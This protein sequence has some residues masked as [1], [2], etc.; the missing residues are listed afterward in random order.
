MQ[1]KLL[2]AAAA[3]AALAA[4]ASAHATTYDLGNLGG[5]GVITHTSPTV[6]HTAGT[7]TDEFDFTASTGLMEFTTGAY[8]EASPFA[9]TSA[10]FTLYSDATGKAITSSGAFDPQTSVTPTISADLDAGKY[11]L[12]S[13]IT[14]PT[15]SL[16]SYTLTA[17]SLSVSA[18][19]EPSTW[20]LMIAG[21]GMIGA[22]LRR[23]NG[24][25]AAV[26]A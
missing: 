13:T 5:K 18:A 14:V 7:F 12:L 17:T 19:P 8:T 6:N 23:K 4:G 11:Y 10:D 2:V 1:S 24:L 15:G 3:V 25:T 16:G 9:I 21:V 20:A 26:S 22:V